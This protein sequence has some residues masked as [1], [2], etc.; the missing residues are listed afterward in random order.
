MGE[1]WHSLTREQQRMAALSAGGVL[2]T[3][4]V[5][6]ITSAI[7]ALAV[8]AIIAYSLGRYRATHRPEPAKPMPE[9]VIKA[10]PPR[11][12][13]AQRRVR[14]APQTPLGRLFADRPGWSG[15][16]ADPFEPP[17]RTPPEE[18]DPYDSI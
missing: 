13:A 10:A 14:P 2:V 16:P 3:L 15:P 8:A 11:R 18:Q 7:V 4:L 9:P 17:R 1:I 12:P 5:Y 6:L